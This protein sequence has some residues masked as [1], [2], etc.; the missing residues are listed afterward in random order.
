MRLLNS[1]ATKSLV[2]VAKNGWHTGEFTALK[3][4][5]KLEM[6]FRRMNFMFMDEDVL[7]GGFLVQFETD[8][9]LREFTGK[10]INEVCVKSAL[11]EYCF[12]FQLII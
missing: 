12:N 1:Y 6:H 11:Y 5:I 10:V 2:F 4:R 8:F 3:S 7:N 9:E